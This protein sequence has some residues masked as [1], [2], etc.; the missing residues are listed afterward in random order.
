M[1]FSLNKYREFTFG[2]KD[3]TWGLCF[4]WECLIHL[5][6]YPILNNYCNFRKPS[7]VTRGSFEH[8]FLLASLRTL[9]DCNYFK[10]TKYIKRWNEKVLYKGSIQNSNEI[11]WSDHQ[12]TTYNTFD[13][14]IDLYWLTK[15]LNRPETR[16]SIKI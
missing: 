1:L 4:V 9:H 5:K 10:D 16:N 13:S 7:L 3:L 15:W 8:I 11:M 2:P 6:S 12:A 14:L